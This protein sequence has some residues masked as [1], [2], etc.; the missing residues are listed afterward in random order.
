MPSII[1]SLEGA[2]RAGA[3]EGRHGAAQLVGLARREAAATIAICIA[4]SWNSGT[5]SVV[6]RTASQRLVLGIDGL[7][8]P[9]RGA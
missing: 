2:D 4:C 8:D 7:L 6:P 1:L 3:L 5:P 9:H